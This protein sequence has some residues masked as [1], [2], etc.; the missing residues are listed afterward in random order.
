MPHGDVRLRSVSYGTFTFAL[1][2]VRYFVSIPVRP[3]GRP[4]LCGAFGTFPCALG[5]VWCDRSI[6]VR[7]GGSRVRWCALC[8][9]PVALGV[10]GFVRGCSVHSC[11]PWGSSGSFVC[12]RPIHV[13]AMF[14]RVR[15]VHS[16][17][18]KVIVGCVRSI[19]SRPGGDLDC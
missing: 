18:P 13:H 7:P 10:V 8:P 9:L 6:P 2:I 17:A 19:P 3:G 5:V 11:A 14:V 1:G 16:R 4:V 15:S 12:V